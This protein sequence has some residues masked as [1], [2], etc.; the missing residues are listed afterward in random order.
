MPADRRVIRAGYPDLCSDC[1]NNL[2]VG[3]QIYWSSST[4]E[5][6]C[7]PSCNTTVQNN[8]DYKSEQSNTNTNSYQNQWQKLCR[9]LRQC[10][11]A[12]MPDPPNITD[13]DKYMIFEDY[14]EKLIIGIA[15]ELV[16][17]DQMARNLSRYLPRNPN[18]DSPRL[19]Y[20]WPT[21]VAE[22]Q[23]GCIKIA[24]ILVIN[25]TIRRE[26]EHG[27]HI[28]MFVGSEP[29]FNLQITTNGLTDNSNLEAV[30]NIIGEELPFGN[31]SSMI[32][33]INEIGE[34]IGFDDISFLNPNLLE[35]H[36][37][38]NPG[39]YNVAVVLPRKN[40]ELFNISLIRDL[41]EL[42]RVEDW[43]DTAAALLV[44]PLLE[45]M[46]GTNISYPLT[47][48]LETNHSQEHILERFRKYPLT[49]VT[50]PPG[51]GKTQ[52]VVNAV[53]NEW[54]DDH[55]VLITS[56]NNQAVD[57]VTDRANKLS[58]GMLIRTGNREIRNRRSKVIREARILA[59]NRVEIGEVKIGEE[60]IRNLRSR[61]FK[62]MERRDMFLEQLQSQAF[63]D[64]E[65]LDTVIKLEKT[66]QT[67]WNE[68]KAPDLQISLKKVHSK[69]RRLK[70]ALFFPRRRFKRF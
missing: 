49:V 46:T 26:V 23:R 62:I 70:R 25:V 68:N 20:G 48:P 40:Q 2:E 54:L 30:H 60:E 31:I 57:V 22:D 19:I 24:P 41:E 11:L 36:L 44:E 35:R 55:T 15:D 51:T 64:R 63:L 43:T 50:G 10:I 39:I 59:Q 53:A 21:L 34:A 27:E 32:N 33:K 5:T 69:V 17:S 56:T 45:Q 18:D 66:R 14:N 1:D 7:Y 38:Q 28:I 13:S 47:A 12:Q 37:D 16:V 4:C 29:D 8:S 61:H 9:Y 3:D 67:I 42:E 58:Q 52:L 65:M 6:W